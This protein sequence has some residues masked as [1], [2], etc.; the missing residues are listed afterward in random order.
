MKSD[1]DCRAILLSGSGKGIKI[2]SG[3]LQSTLFDDFV[4]KIQAFSAGIDLH[5]FSSMATG[6]TDDPGRLAFF[7][8]K[9]IEEYQQ[10]MSSVEDVTKNISV[11]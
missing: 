6:N 1:Q 8:K 2:S 5:E 7:M 3:L 9:M 4:K 11:F 10:S